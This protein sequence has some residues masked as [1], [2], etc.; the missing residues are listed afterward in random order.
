MTFEEAKKQAMQKF[1]IPPEA[2]KIDVEDKTVF[3]IN[4]K[5]YK[6]YFWDK[7]SDWVCPVP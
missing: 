3:F 7:G 4:A 1:N 6:V 2:L 5:T